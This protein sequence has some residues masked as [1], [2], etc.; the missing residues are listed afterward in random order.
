MVTKMIPSISALNY[1][2]RLIEAH[3]TDHSG[4][5]PTQGGSAGSPEKHR[6]SRP[7]YPLQ[8]ER[9]KIQRTHAETREVKGKTGAKKT[10]LPSPSN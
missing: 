10:H 7:S 9:Q 3:R 1:E 4:E 2:E 8:Y 6:E 5:P